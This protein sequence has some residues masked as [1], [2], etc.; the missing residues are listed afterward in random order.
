MCSLDL[1]E[2]VPTVSRGHVRAEQ[3]SF[4]LKSCV[5]VGPGVLLVHGLSR[6][7]C[8][9]AGHSRLQMGEQRCFIDVTPLQCLAGAGGA[10]EV[11]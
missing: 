4:L 9:L 2:F 1:L 10:A 7:P 11:W 8:A 3:W 5:T 6:A